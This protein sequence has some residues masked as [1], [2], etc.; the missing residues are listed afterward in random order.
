MITYYT[1]E[2][3]F[4]KSRSQNYMRGDGL[5]VSSKVIGRS[6]NFC[7]VESKI[8]KCTSEEINWIEECLKNNKYIPFI[9]EKYIN[10]NYTN[11]L[12]LW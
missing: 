12:I 9:K 2:D 7:Y 1:D 5:R 8:R 11:E 10:N 4:V 6:N 3:A